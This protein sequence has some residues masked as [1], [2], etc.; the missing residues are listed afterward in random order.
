MP[1]MAAAAAAATAAANSSA[2]LLEFTRIQAALAIVP[3]FDGQK[4]PLRAFIHDVE[5]A[6]A[7]CPEGAEMEKKFLKLII[8]KLRGAARDAVEGKNFDDLKGFAK[9]LKKNFFSRISSL[10]PLSKSN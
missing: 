7:M 6:L 5:E 1:E 10:L 4:P 8:T 2:A 3:N 9:H